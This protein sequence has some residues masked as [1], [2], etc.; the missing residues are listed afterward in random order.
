MAEGGIKCWGGDRT[1][2][3]VVNLHRG[4]GVSM[5]SAIRFL[6]LFA[7]RMAAPMWMCTHSDVT[8]RRWSAR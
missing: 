4:L 5:L 3:E 6:A 7:G 1:E 2:R 8:R